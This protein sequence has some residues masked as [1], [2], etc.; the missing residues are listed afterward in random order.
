MRKL[1]LST[2][3]AL[4]LSACI[5]TSGGVSVS[6]VQ[7]AAVLACNFLPAATTVTSLI[8]ANNATAITV[9]ELAAAICAV[10]APKTAKRRSVPGVV[11]PPGLKIEGHFVS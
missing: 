6:S 8:L 2:C 7:Q 9:E 3:A 4:G 5:T 1:L 10:V 11:I